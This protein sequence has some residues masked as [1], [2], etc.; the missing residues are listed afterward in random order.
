MARPAPLGPTGP[1][2]TVT[3]ADA[4]A[5]AA[6]TTNLVTQFN[7]LLANL[8]AAGLCALDGQRHSPQPERAAAAALSG[9]FRVTE[10]I[11]MKIV[12]YAICKNEIKFVDRWMD[13]MGEADEIVVLDTGSTDGT[14]ARLRAR[15]A[16]VSEAIIAPWRFDAARNRSLALV[17]E[18]ADICVCTDL[19]EVFHP[20]WRAALEQ[21]W[22]PE[23]QQA[24]YRYTWSF[25]PDGREGVVFWYEKIHSRRGWQWIHPVHEILAAPTARARGQITIP[26]IQLDHHPDSSKSR[27]QYS[28]AHCLELSV[29][30]T[31]EDD[32]SMHYLGREYFFYGRWDDC[33]ATLQRHLSMPAARW[34][35]ERAASMRYIARAL[36]QK[37]RGSRRPGSAV[38]G[39]CRSAAP[40]RTLYRSGLAAVPAKRNTGPGVLYFTA[41][42]LAIRERPQSYI[43]EAAPWGS[44]PHDLRAVAWYQLGRLQ[45]L[46]RSPR[47]R[48]AVPC[49]STAAEQPA[50]HCRRPGRTPPLSASASAL[51]RA[52]HP[53]NR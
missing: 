47:R 1:A 31:P 4:V 53:V 25:Q 34:A 5:D 50:A 15:G 28:I 36:E 20:A 8:R 3:P 2:G 46:G 13:S 48:S 6:D 40:A 49:R 52:S 22:T 9:S 44:L 19:D 14:A 27:S 30:E 24:H 18:D 43:C 26:G 38:A 33:I 42:A 7:Q 51:Q 17:P 41:C 21:A 35:D 37:G 16:R 39:H 23:A 12:V 32:R 45:E 10:N 29:Q 11:A